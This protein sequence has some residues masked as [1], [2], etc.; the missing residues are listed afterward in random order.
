MQF[1]FYLMHRF[2]DIFFKPFIFLKQNA[3]ETL[4]NVSSLFFHSFGVMSYLLI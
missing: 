1:L 3:I 4:F 2:I